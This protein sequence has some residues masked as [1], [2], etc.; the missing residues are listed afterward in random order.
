MSEIFTTETRRHGEKR[1]KYGIIFSVLCVSVV[2]F[3]L[4]SWKEELLATAE[5]NSDKEYVIVTDA[6]GYEVKIPFPARRLVVTN[7]DAAEVLCALGAGDRIIGVTAHTA[8]MCSDLFSQLKGKAIIGSW[9]NPSLE[10]I[11]ELETNVVITYDMWRPS[12]KEFAEQL[13][14]F[15]IS[16][17]RAPCYRIDRLAEDVKILGKIVGKEE[18]AQEY[19]EY[20]QRILDEV[21]SRLRSI[22]KKVR[23]YGESY[24]DYV[25]VSKGSGAY[26]LLKRAGVDNIAGNQPISSP[27]MA[28]E[29]VVDENPEV[30]IKAASSGGVRMGYGIL[31]KEA[32]SNF[33]NR[34]VA[35]PVWDRIEAVKKGRVYII[36]AEIWADPRAAIGILYVAKWCYPELFKDIDPEAIHR[37]WL[38]KWHRKE[39]KGIYVYPNEL[40]E[41]GQQSVAR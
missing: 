16:V 15:G 24:G 36:S 38:M 33:R 5:D 23:V 21:Q 31:D 26:E 13:A 34:L 17:V 7:S 14:P 25:A 28:P 35:R 10:K 12:Q 9:Q 22:K 6:C 37:K 20:Y 3:V 27:R 2:I 1:G 29:W 18:E 40:S 39:L 19:I 41:P 11:I 8:R 30:I 32:I 4:A